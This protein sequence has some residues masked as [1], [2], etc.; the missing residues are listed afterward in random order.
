MYRHL[1]TATP[2]IQGE[3]KQNF[4]TALGELREEDPKSATRRL[5][6]AQRNQRIGRTADPKTQALSV[7]ATAL[8][9][10]W[11]L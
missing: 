6:I 8:A 10:L 3:L 1:T 2:K 9:T 11:G 4:E 5:P 7:A